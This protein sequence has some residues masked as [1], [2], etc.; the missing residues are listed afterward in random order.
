MRKIILSINITEDGFVADPDGSLDWHFPYWNH[1]MCNSMCR[2]LC[3]CDTILLGRNT[4]NAF[5]GYWMLKENDLSI[6]AMDVPMAYMM[7]S[8]TK[9]VVSSSLSRLPWRYSHVVNG[10]ILQEIKKLKEQQGKDIIVLGS[11]QLVSLLIQHDL[12]DEYYIWIHPITIRS[13]KQLSKLTKY[14]AKLKP[15]HVE[16]FDC[17]VIKQGFIK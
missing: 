1:E 14:L 13:G 12:I 10:N 8:Y 9:I 6:P 7:N 15:N 3:E 11:C 5:A 2:I 16:Q 4:Y 17:G